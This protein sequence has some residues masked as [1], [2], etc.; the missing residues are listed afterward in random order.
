MLAHKRDSAARSTA[1]SQRRT[2]RNSRRRLAVAIAEG[3]AVTARDGAGAAAGRP[4]GGRAR[5]ARL[6]G[7]SAPCWTSA[8]ASHARRRCIAHTSRPYVDA[9]E[10]ARP[11][12]TRST[13]RSWR[14]GRLLPRRRPAR[15]GP[16]ARAPPR[17]STGRPGGTRTPYNVALYLRRQVLARAGPAGPGPIGV[18]V[19]VPRQ[20]P[21]AGRLAEEPAG[22]ARHRR[23]AP[24]RR[25]RPCSPS[26]RPSGPRALYRASGA[27]H[28]RDPAAA[29]RRRGRSSRL[30]QAPC[31]QASA[32]W[33]APHALLDAA[34]DPAS[35]RS[36]STG[37]APA[38]A[39]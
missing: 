30:T 15:A 19:D 10:A 7:R 9:A 25:R 21:V 16:P 6:R 17:S 35:D 26:G 28:R 31:W 33:R 12:P 24:G 32:T 3:R 20:D 22:R 37:P 2:P 8:S 14:A 27:A 29:Q 34:I 23:P 1:R 11:T 39:C 4:G 36:S 18:A 13:R 38:A 5:S